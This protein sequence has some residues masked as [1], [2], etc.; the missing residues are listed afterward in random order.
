LSGELVLSGEPKQAGDLIRLVVGAPGEPAA[1]RPVLWRQQDEVVV[2]HPEREED[3]ISLDELRGEG[4]RREL[5]L[6]LGGR[7][8]VVC[9]TLALVPREI[10]IDWQRPADDRWRP[11]LEQAARGELPAWSFSLT[12]SESP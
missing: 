4:A 5:D 3:W 8:G 9:Y 7:A 1:W 2:L 12:L 11:I 10:E 6:V